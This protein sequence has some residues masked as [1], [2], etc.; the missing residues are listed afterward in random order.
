M[1]SATVGTGGKAAGEI[2]ASNGGTTYA[3]I[4]AGFTRALSSARMVPAGYTAYIAGASVGSVSGAGKT[5]IVTLAA[6]EIY[7]FSMIDPLAFFPLAGISMED[8]SV[9]YEFP[10]L[11]K[12]SEGNIFAMTYTTSGAATL[13]GAW[14]G[15]LEKN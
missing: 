13:T 10:I 3:E 4:N 7:G 9:T 5:A 2:T 14:Y 6:T 12:V 15:W 8:N 11:I 1:V